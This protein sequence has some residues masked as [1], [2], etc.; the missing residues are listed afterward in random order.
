MV[1]LD[2]RRPPAP[3]PLPP[4]V[5]RTARRIPAASPGSQGAGGEGGGLPRPPVTEAERVGLGAEERGVVATVAVVVVGV[6]ESALEAEAARLERA[7]GGRGRGAP[8]VLEYC[9]EGTLKWKRIRP[10]QISSERTR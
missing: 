2:L 6:P 10:V 9:L 3:P 1:L 7:R 5:S 4:L 8:V